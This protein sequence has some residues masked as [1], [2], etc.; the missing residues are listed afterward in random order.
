MQ[1]VAWK[2]IENEKY[3]VQKIMHILQTPIAT[4]FDP[5][6]L[7]FLFKKILLNMQSR[8]ILLVQYLLKY[9]SY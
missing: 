4:E 2:C 1:L 7:S 6:D 8:T 9:K 5:F 3:N